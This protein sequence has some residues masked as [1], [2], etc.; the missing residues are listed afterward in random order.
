MIYLYSSQTLPPLESSWQDTYIASRFLSY[1][2]GTKFAPFYVDEYGRLLS[3]LD[4]NAILSGKSDPKSD[5][6]EWFSFIAMQPDIQTITADVSVAVQLAERLKTISETKKVM[7]LTTPLDSPR[8]LL[9][10][11]SPHQIYP[12]IEEVFEGE[13]P[14]FEGWYVD[15]SHRIRHGL[16]QTAG[17]VRDEK[18][19]STA[20][21]VATSET[22]VIIG[23]V[24]TKSTYRGQGLA[25]QCLRKLATQNVDK[26]VMIAPKN[27]RAEALYASMGFSVCGEIGQIL[28]KG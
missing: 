26:V 21:T 10:E 19:V 24:A 15:V 27:H 1:G 23:A 17:V 20:M 3:I 12:L 4:G 6:E 9:T 25:G 14:P 5:L 28:L 2:T 7:R 16:C 22:A 11:P 18:L 8:I 13:V